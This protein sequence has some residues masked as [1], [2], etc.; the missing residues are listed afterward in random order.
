LSVT[1][2]QRY[3]NYSEMLFELENPAKVRPF[4]KPGTPLLERNPLLFYKTGFFILL[5][6]IIG[7]LSVISRLLHR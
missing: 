4:H 1:P 5:A 7:L 2:D 6:I 3:E